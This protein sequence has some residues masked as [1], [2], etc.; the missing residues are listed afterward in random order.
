ML[1]TPEIVSL[2]VIR[3]FTIGYS[4]VVCRGLGCSTSDV[5]HRTDDQRVTLVLK[6]Q[7]YN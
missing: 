7:V 1:P 6:F 4:D 2:M 5:L 3:W